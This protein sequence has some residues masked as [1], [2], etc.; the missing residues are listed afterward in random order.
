MKAGE[1]KR[2]Q[3]KTCWGDAPITDAL[4]E[5]TYQYWKRKRKFTKQQPLINWKLSGKE[6]LQLMDD[7][8]ITYDDVGRSPDSF[9]LARHGDTGDYE[10]GNCRYITMRENLQ[11]RKFSEETL[12]SMQQSGAARWDNIVTPHGVFNSKSQAGRAIGVTRNMVRRRVDSNKH[13]D[14]YQVDNS[15]DKD[16]SVDNL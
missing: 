6:L 5:R 16:N 4:T 2:H 9:Q 1:L 11:E 12:D 10:V 3:N 13:P 14:W 7:A 8:G 15:V